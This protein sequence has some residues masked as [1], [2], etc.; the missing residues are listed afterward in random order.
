M[1][2]LRV[3]I[4]GGR[5]ELEILLKLKDECIETT[6][7]E[8]YERL[9]KDLIERGD[10]T[11]EK[12]LEFLRDFLENAIFSKLRKAGFDGSEEMTVRVLKEDGEFSVEEC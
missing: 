1:S 6:A 10:E 3:I 4:R 9:A 5:W 11:K 2:P 8:E 12:K 7:E